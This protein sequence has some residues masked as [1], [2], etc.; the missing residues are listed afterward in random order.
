MKDKPV[1]GTIDALGGWHVDYAVCLPVTDKCGVTY[2]SL[3]GYGNFPF[4]RF[5]DIPVIDYRNVPGK[6]LIAAINIR[7]CFRPKICHPLL[8]SGTLET[9]LNA[10]REL[11]IPII[12]GGQSC[13]A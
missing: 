9:Y 12:Y 2:H 1:F 5:P 11:E 3:S 7:E 8:Y 6:Q 4:D 13:S 10:I